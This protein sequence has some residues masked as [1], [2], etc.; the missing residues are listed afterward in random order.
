MCRGYDKLKI[1]G[2]LSHEAV[3][4][5]FIVGDVAELKKRATVLH[6]G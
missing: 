3:W 6:S 1:I 5:D 4:N 2:Y